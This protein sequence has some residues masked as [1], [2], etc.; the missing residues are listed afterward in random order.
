MFPFRFNQSQ[1]QCNQISNLCSTMGQLNGQAAMPEK[2]KLY[3]LSSII[4]IK[5]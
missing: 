1:S 4:Y 5:F 3:T 2:E